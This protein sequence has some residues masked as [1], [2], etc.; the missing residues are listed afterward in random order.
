MRILVVDDE[1]EILSIVSTFLGSHGY[2]V[3]TANNGDEALDVV[4][5]DTTIRA[6]LLDVVMPGHNGIETL[7]EMM[8]FDPRPQVIMMTASADDK[9]FEAVRLGA[10][11]YVLKPIDFDALIATLSASLQRSSAS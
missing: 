8:Q 1:A 9:V 2:D 6:V 7:R 10:V 3:V 4:G 11:D 5:A